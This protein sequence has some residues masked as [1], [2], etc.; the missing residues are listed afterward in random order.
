MSAG[1]VHRPRC[2]VDHTDCSLNL[3]KLADAASALHLTPLGG[4]HDD[5]TTTILLGP[6]E[7]GFWA[8]VSNR[9]EFSGD[10]PMDTWSRWAITALGY[11]TVST[12]VFPFD[13]PPHNPFISWALRS[14]EAW[15]SP[16]GLLVHKDAGLL[17]SYRGALIFDHLIDLPTPTPCPCDSCVAQP[18]R[19]ACPVD[20]ITPTGYALPLC[21]AHIDVDPTCAAGCCVRTACPV[22][23]AYPRDPAQT[24]FHM[25]AF[26]P[27]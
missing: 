9:P 1:I 10:N 6:L 18:C 14:G 4:F 13:G 3:D 21:K 7:P 5:G 20:A 27:T 12:P 11:V 24:A 25:K 8:Y 15:Q 19:H 16:V 17:V 23:Q 22:S 2:G 26:H